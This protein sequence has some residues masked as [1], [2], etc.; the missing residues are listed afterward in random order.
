VDVLLRQFRDVL[1][2]PEGDVYHRV[3]NIIKELS[4]RQRS[5]T[6]D[7]WSAVRLLLENRK[8]VPTSEHELVEPWQALF[9]SSF[10][11]I[12]MVAPDLSGEGSETRD[13][14]TKLNCLS[15]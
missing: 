7:H 4:R 12:Y 1:D 9:S 6:T 5:L 3:K 2:N 11:G 15:T 10:Q 14:L 13:F 8:W